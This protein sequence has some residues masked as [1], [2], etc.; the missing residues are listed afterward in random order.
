[1][2]H[3]EFETSVEK[4]AEQAEVGVR[5]ILKDLIE[6][7]LKKVRDELM[8]QAT[9]DINKLLA[10]VALEISKGIEA[11]IMAAR[12]P[13]DGVI[14]VRIA[15]DKKQVYKRVER[16]FITEVPGGQPPR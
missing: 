2:A 4:L 8:K 13:M 9:D 14:E 6:A 3:Y 16:E 5:P 1:M 10:D 7:R 15:V 12:S 11:R